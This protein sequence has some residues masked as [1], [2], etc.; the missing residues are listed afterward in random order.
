MKPGL[1]LSTKFVYETE[2]R[3]KNDKGNIYLLSLLYP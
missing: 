1:R 3:H 2:K